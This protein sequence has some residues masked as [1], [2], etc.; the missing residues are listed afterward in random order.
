MLFAIHAEMDDEFDLC[1]GADSFLDRT[2]PAAG[3]SLVADSLLR[4]L[5]TCGITPGKDNFPEKYRRN[6]ITDWIVTALD[7]AGRDSE[8]T[9]LCIAD[10]D[11]ADSY[12]RLVRRL[13]RLGRKDEAAAWI[14]RGIESS[15][16]TH[17][18]VA[19]ELQAIRREVWEKDGDLLPAAGLRA[20]EFLCNPSYETY[21]T[22]KPAAEKAGVWDAVEGPVMQ[23]LTTGS[24]PSVKR[25][26]NA[27]VPLVFDSLPVSGLIEQGSWKSQNG[28]FF[29]ILI[30][31]A[32]A[33]RQFE[34]AVT[35][36]DRLRAERTG[37]GGYYYPENR[38]WD[39]VAGRFPDRALE[40]WMG[41]ADREARTA[42]PKGYERAIRYLKK[43]RA[44][45]VAQGHSGEWAAYL[46]GVRVEHARKKKFT[47]MLDVLEGQKI[48]K[49]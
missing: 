31:R 12:A 7:K 19:R 44:L 38:L 48:L 23:Y 49:F 29:A 43:I 15:G 26:G 9:D 4:E 11:L 41:C 17:S 46:A 42:Q 37:S 2:W 20:E 30:D 5:D 32:L 24:A 47:G 39:E 1:G 8:A 16:K 45:M 18:G 14:C 25:E 10:A 28:P 33:S 34:E 27:G 21:C 22:L 36:F 3:W 35:W 6:R 13:L 40:F